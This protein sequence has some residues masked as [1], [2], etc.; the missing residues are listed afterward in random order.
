MTRQV[1]HPFGATHYTPCAPLTVT[2]PRARK[3]FIEHIY[4]LLMVGG[5]AAVVL[6]DNLLFEGGAGET[7]RRRLRYHIPR[8]DHAHPPIR[9]PRLGGS[10]L[11]ADHPPARPQGDVT[12]LGS[13]TGPKLVRV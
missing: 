8:S 4:R 2:G 11:A 13:E 6:L 12:S 5:R 1:G 3:S 7:T 9:Q 10:D